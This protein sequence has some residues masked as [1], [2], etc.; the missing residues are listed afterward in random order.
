MDDELVK[1][2]LRRR[3][4]HW[5]ELEALLSQHQK[6][7]KVDLADTEKFLRSYQQIQGDFTVARS[8]IPQSD[9]TRKLQALLIET[10]Q[11]VAKPV[12]YFIPEM[13]N[14]LGYE[15]PVILLKLIPKFLAITLLF[16]LSIVVGWVVIAQFP[17]V[18]NAFFSPEMINGV[19]RGQLWTEGIF[20]VTPSSV[21]AFSIMTNNIMVSFTAF[22]LG[23]LYGIGTLYIVVLN[24]LLLGCAFSFT[25][26]HGLSFRLLDFVVAHGCVELSVIVLAATA[27]FAMGDALAHPGQQSRA[28][29]FRQAAKEG[30]YICALCVPFLI[31]AGIIE[32]YVSPSELPFVF[33]L[34]IGVGYWLIFVYILTGKPFRHR[35]NP[36]ELP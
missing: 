34:A 6:E 29:V 4:E 5:K 30:C 24:G 15:L 16:S 1:R 17:D 2:W 9:L 7:K 25:A 22:A 18:I 32:G 21:A 10:N 13:R 11:E 33:K 26:I 27:G 20:S 35:A 12:A 31:A 36:T 3:V 14:L 8:E 23:A 19:H 28:S